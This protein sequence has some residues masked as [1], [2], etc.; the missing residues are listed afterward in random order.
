MATFTKYI[1]REQQYA[2]A[3][4]L[5]DYINADVE[6]YA[7]LQRAT[8]NEFDGNFAKLVVQSMNQKRSAQVV[9]EQAKTEMVRDLRYMIDK[10][11]K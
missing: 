3:L 9:Y 8:G 2:A 4:A 6:A 7:T 5:L 10:C 1:V 11:P